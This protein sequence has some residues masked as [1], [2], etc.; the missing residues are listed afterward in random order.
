MPESTSPDPSTPDVNL[1]WCSKCRLHSAFKNVWGTVTRI[2]PDEG[3]YSETLEVPHCLDCHAEMYPIK[4]YKTLVLAMNVTLSL[5]WLSLVLC[6]IY[7]FPLQEYFWLAFLAYTALV[8]FLWFAPTKA[9]R[10]YAEWKNWAEEQKS[11]H[12]LD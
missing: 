8:F 1:P 4:D 9:R 5:G 6:S 2:N 7:V 12:L 11:F 3:T 10:R